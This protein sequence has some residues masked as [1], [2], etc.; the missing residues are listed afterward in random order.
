[1]KGLTDKRDADR[2]LAAIRDDE[3]KR[4]HTIVVAPNPANAMAMARTVNT[5]YD[6]TA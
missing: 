5:R 1:M 2:E 3:D 4:L 6:E